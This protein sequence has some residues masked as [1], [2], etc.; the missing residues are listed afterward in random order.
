VSE[1]SSVDDAALTNAYCVVA[2]RPVHRG[3]GSPGLQIWHTPPLKEQNDISS[4]HLY[5]YDACI[6]ISNY[7]PSNIAIYYRPS[8]FPQASKLGLQIFDS[9]TYLIK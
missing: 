7:S 2:A 4:V 6:F 1:Q 8:L 5:Q 9:T 3:P